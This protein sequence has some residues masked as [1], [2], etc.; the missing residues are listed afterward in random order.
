MN[1]NQEYL[2]RLLLPPL[3]YLVARVGNRPFIYR[4]NGGALPSG[5]PRQPIECPSELLFTQPLFATLGY[6]LGALVALATGARSG[7]RNRPRQLQG[8][9]R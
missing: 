2:Y 4:M 5:A 7:P 1:P 9:L 8:A 6:S 3:A